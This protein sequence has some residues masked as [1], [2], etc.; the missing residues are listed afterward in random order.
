[1]RGADAAKTTEGVGDPEG[2]DHVADGLIMSKKQVQV[3]H[4]KK[5]RKS[6]D[7]TKW[8]DEE[9]RAIFGTGKE[10]ATGAA[11]DDP[12]AA[13]ASTMKVKKSKKAKKEKKAK[14]KKKSKKKSDE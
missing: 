13:L 4:A 5:M 14:A 2:E 12:F 8:G 10:E 3:G 11:N 1:M 9:Y 7:L 6:K